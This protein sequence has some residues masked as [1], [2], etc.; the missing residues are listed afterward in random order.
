VSVYYETAEVE[1]KT[2][3]VVKA[4]FNANINI[5]SV[6]ADAET[7]ENSSSRSTQCSAMFNRRNR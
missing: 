3:A 4:N 7:L 5:Y 1:M 6:I 2:Y